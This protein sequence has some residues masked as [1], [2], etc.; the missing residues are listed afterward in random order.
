[1]G[2]RRHLQRFGAAAMTPIAVLPAAAV[3]LALGSVLPVPFVSK[4]LLAAGDALLKY[5][6][7]IIAMGVAVGLAGGEGI[8]GF[9]GGIVYVI[10]DGVARS[11]SPDVS[12]HV[13]AGI[14]AGVLSALLYLRFHR[15]KLPEALSF[16]G[17]QRSVPIV[18]AFAAVAA[19]LILGSAGPLLQA[20]LTS[21]GK[22][23]L[24]G[25]AWGAGLYGALE[26]LLIPTG[27]HHFLNSFILMLAGSYA[28]K[29]G[30]LMRFFAGDP[31]AGFFMGG[32]FAIKLFGLP[33]ACLAMY[34]E[35]RPEAKAAIKGLMLTAAL[36]SFLTGITEPVEFAFLFTAPVLFLVHIALS[37]SS[38]LL[39]GLLGIR[40]GFMSSA[41]V[42]E[43]LANLRL[44]ERGLL[45]IPIGLGY[46]CAYY[47][48]FRLLI[49]K[50]NLSTPGRLEAEADLPVQ[51][52][53]SAQADIASAIIAGLGGRDNLVSIDS[54]LTRLRVAYV[55]ADLIDEA[56]LRACGALGFVR[57]QGV[58]QVVMGTQSDALRQSIRAILRG[59]GQ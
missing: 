48:L 54:C 2:F 39:N 5:I 6:G 52:S 8:A 20:G 23:M 49:R 46:A 15:T 34:H 13:L 21:A 30:D 9:T 22:W 31:Q 14:I 38:F 50:L 41:G 47:F 58:I 3:I 28:G 45:I 53:A 51:A 40:H 29:T 4:A 33:A 56:A 12:L 37:G 43:Y 1:M 11:I 35:A 32:A 17:G 7:L 27:L 55:K 25:G 16:F 10:M 57:G 59:R 42:V 18:G 24:A 44:A 36:T 19:G 26:R